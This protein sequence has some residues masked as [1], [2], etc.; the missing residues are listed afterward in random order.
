MAKSLAPPGSTRRILEHVVAEFLP[1]GVQADRLDAIDLE[2][3]VVALIAR[4]AIPA[5]PSRSRL[6]ALATEEPA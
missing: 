2:K 6:A 3:E 1:Y 5:E 4:A